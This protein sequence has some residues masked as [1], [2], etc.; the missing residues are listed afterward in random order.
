[1]RELLDNMSRG[2]ME[3]YVPQLLP[4]VQAALVDTDPAVRQVNDQGQGLGICAGY[5][6]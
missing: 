4:I 3:E 5:Q 2:Q 1:M 6:V